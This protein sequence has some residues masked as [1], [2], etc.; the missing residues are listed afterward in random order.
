VVFRL[1]TQDVERNAK[2]NNK[3]LVEEKHTSQI[4]APVVVIKKVF[5]A[6]FAGD[7]SPY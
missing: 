1:C 4:D 6:S 7:R 5:A 2:V 3:R